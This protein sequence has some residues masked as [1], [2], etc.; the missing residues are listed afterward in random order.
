MD[1]AISAHAPTTP[2][3]SGRFWPGSIISGLVI[4]FLV[5]DGVTKVIEIGPV[6]DACARLGIPTETV[7]GIGLTL[8]ACTAVYAIPQTCV[9]G[10]ILLT[11]YLGGA[12]AIHIRGGSG[13]FEIAFAIATG[14]LVW[15]GLLL[16]EPRLL[17]TILLRQ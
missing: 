12:V 6:L 11:A 10:A 17:W 1:T 15:V 16:R 5:F 3:S 7:A 4:L 9:L 2:R 8:L 13:T 14:A